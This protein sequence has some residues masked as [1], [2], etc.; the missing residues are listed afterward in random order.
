[1]IDQVND[2]QQKDNYLKKLN[3]MVLEG[4]Q[5]SSAP[6][7]QKTDFK[8]IIK[9]FNIHKTSNI[10]INDIQHEI[11]EVKTEIRQLKQESEENE[12]RHFNFKL[13]MNY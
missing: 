12:A 9:T 3:D 7:K 5:G 13:K 8:D 4:G 1:M 6:I 10:S 11:R 2:P